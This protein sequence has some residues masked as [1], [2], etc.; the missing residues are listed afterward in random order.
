MGSQPSAPPDNTRQRERRGPEELERAWLLLRSQARRLDRIAKDQGWPTPFA[1]ARY[2]ILLLLDR[3]T[4]YGLSAR[5]LASSLEV[6]RSTLAHHLDV[7]EGA[8]FIR[9]APWTI[10][11]RRKVAV[12]LTATGRYVLRCLASSSRRSG[13][14]ASGATQA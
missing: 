7:L 13:S 12:R 3:A 14:E 6:S 1:P 4:A 11:D 2:L 9:R 10:Y 5:Q 8:G